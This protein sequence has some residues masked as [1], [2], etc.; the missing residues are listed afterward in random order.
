MSTRQN[1]IALVNDKGIK[2][3]P[4]APTFATVG[5]A[6]GLVLAANLD[7]RSVR[8]INTSAN[9]ISLA[10]GF[11]AVLYSGL[12]LFPSG[13]YNMDDYDFSEYDIFGIA[14]GAAS[15]LAIQEYN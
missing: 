13:V 8:M 1:G 3:I 10:F 7:R 15:N 9:I 2:L 11:P 5:L 12:T 14:S 4:L 6:S